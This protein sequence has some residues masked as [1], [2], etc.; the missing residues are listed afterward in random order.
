MGFTNIWNLHNI[1]SH[2]SQKLINSTQ[3]FDVMINEEFFGDSFLMFAHKFKVPIVTICELLH[4][5]NWLS[6]TILLKKIYFSKVLLD[7]LTSW[8]IHKACS[9]HLLRMFH[10]G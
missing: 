9:L 7:I 10:I 6:W 3:H 5:T 8:H 1:E 4:V 2:A